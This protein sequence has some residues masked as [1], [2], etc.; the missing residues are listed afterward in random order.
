MRRSKT[1]VKQL[2]FS[3]DVSAINEKE[4]SCNKACRC[5]GAMKT[6][7][8]WQVKLFQGSKTAGEVNPKQ[9][10]YKVNLDHRKVFDKEENRA[11]VRYSVTIA[12]MQYGLTKKDFRL[13]AFKLA[14][15][16]NK[17]IPPEWIEN[18][19]A[20]EQWTRQLIQ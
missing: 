11:L 5:F 4:K 8:Q 13:L 6:I 12:R 14:Q 2:K 19:I 16:K 7:L 18:S 1:G 10:E 17:K 15:S 3:K 20:G 9:Y